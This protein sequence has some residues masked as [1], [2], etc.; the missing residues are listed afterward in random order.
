MPVETTAVSASTPESNLT[1]LPRKISRL[2]VAISGRCGLCKEI[3]P[4]VRPALRWLVSWYGQPTPSIARPA[5]MA[6]TLNGAPGGGYLLP[7]RFRRRFAT[8][9]VCPARFNRPVSVI[10]VMS[11]VTQCAPRPGGSNSR[12]TRP[13]APSDEQRLI[14]RAYNWGNGRRQR[15]NPKLAEAT[16]RATRRRRTASSIPSAPAK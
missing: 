2:I 7:D 1:I 5:G 16:A 10:P 3:D 9:G 13:P 4:L 15:G 14:A 8:G 11:A 6:I 12:R